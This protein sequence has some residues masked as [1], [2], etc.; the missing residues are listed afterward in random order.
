MNETLDP[1]HAIFR[2]ADA[3]DWIEVLGAFATSVVLDYGTPETLA[4]DAIVDRWRNALEPLD[5]TE[6]RLFD[7]DVRVEG[8]RAFVTSRFSAEHRLR[9]APGG[10]E[11]RLE[12]RYEHDVVRTD[13]WRV[14]RMR[15]IPEASI[16]NGAMVAEG[17]DRARRMPALRARNRASV[18][19]F[20]DRLEA[21]DIDGFAALFAE[22][23]AQI[24]PYAP[25]GFPSELRG[26][27]SIRAQYAGIAE[28]FASMRFVDRTILATLDPER[29]VA[30]FRGEVAL[31]EGGRYDNRYVSLFRVENGLVTEVVEHFDPRVLRSFLDGQ[32][33]PQT[34]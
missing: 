30:T 2:G 1:V 19:A 20:F 9:N 32:S 34:S 23:A 22:G 33:S 4:P 18:D 17:I 26:R 29:F 8:D 27:E 14:T 3:R 25:P 13:R 24:M 5:R 15:M 6:H 11:W 21:F 31:R 7:I 12:G 28:R 16:G 10:D